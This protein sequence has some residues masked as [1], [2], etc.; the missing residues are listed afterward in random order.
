MIAWLKINHPTEVCSS[1][2]KSPSS[3]ASCVLSTESKDS[4]DSK[5]FNLSSVDALSEILALPCPEPRTKSKCK[6]ALNAKAY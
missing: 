6:A 5:K 3:L 1:T 2:A 4:T